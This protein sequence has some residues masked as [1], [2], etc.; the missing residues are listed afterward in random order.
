[1]ETKAVYNEYTQNIKGVVNYQEQQIEIKIITLKI[2]LGTFAIIG[3]LALSNINLTNFWIFIN[4][5]IIP[6]L[7]LLAITVNFFN[8]FVFRER[9]KLSF[10]NEALK[11]EKDFEWLPEFHIS[12]IGKKSKST[13]KVIKQITFYLLCSCIL[14]IIVI[15][16]LIFLPTIKTNLVRI[17]IGILGFSIYLI[18]STLLI[19]SAKKTKELFD[20]KFKEQEILQHNLKEDDFLSLIHAKGREYIEY[21]SNIKMRYKNLT[22]TLI[23][24]IFIAFAYIVG[25]QE[26]FFS[27]K[28]SFVGVAD[29][30]VHEN[31]LYL[32]CFIILLATIGV[33]M[34]RYLDLDVSNEQLRPL[35]NYVLSIEKKVKSLTKPYETIAKTVYNK[36]DPIIVD[37]LYYSAF[38]VGIL[39]IGSTVLLSHVRDYHSFLSVCSTFCILSLFFIW[40]IVWL[41]IVYN[42]RLIL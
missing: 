7:A 9:L 30:F 18:Y 34:I 19:F 26:N 5:A 1:M 15:S 28:E 14:F 13:Q 4:S 32:I 36:T 17:L 20:L 23:T 33:R 11:L 29:S 22:I 24:T 27:S 31:K 42:K 25:S 39:I 41:Y 37:Y 12:L 16:A 38:N 6:F 2:V 3:L 8:D 21:F 10:F 35:Y 40:E